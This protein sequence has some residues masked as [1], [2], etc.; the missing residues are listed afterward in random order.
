M[1]FTPLTLPVSGEV[2]LVQPVSPFLL[3]KFRR[4]HLP[5]A[6]PIQKVNMGTKEEPFW[7][8]SENENHP[9]HIKALEKWRQEFEEKIRTYTL[10]LGA[11]IEWTDEKRERLAWLRG[12]N[13]KTGEEIEIESD[14]NFAY[15]SYVAIQSGEDYKTLLQA[16]TEGSRPQEEGIKDATASFRPD[17]N[18]QG[19]D[20]PGEGH[21]LHSSAP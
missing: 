3:A 13:E 2:V 7:E 17:T 16:I 21:I 12:Q 19:A 20:V 5:P 4:K 9:D 6:P 10:A 11:S 8:E 18:G 15:I 1:G 14:D